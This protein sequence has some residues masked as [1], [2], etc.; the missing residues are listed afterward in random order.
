M[1]FYYLLIATKKSTNQRRNQNR[2]PILQ[3][4]T[5]SKKDIPEH[6][7]PFNESFQAPS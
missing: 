7:A 2:S 4:G 3:R 1:H 5:Q 6:V